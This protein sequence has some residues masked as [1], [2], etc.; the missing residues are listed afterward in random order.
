MD[1]EQH[2]AGAF[3]RGSALQRDLPEILVQRDHDAPLRLSQVQQGR[4]L[5]PNA[6]RPRPEYIV[7]VRAKLLD[8]WQCSAAVSRPHGTIRRGESH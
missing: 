8:G 7:T 5:P 2:N 4:V 3:E 6:I 1:L